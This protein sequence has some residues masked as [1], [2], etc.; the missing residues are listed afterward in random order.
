[1]KT[2]ILALLAAALLALTGCG[3]GSFLDDMLGADT[4]NDIEVTG[5]GNNVTIQRGDVI[6][7]PPEPLPIATPEPLATPAPITSAGFG[8]VGGLILLSLLWSGCNSTLI[9]SPN[10]TLL[11]VNSGVQGS[12]TGVGA[13]KD[14]DNG[15]INFSPTIEREGGASVETS[16]TLPGTP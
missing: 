11:G 1:M 15:G 16:A 5:D 12:G 9:L 7:P 4:A 13:G 8:W 2:T 10:L 6:A 14:K 3:S